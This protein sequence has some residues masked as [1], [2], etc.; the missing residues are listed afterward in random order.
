MENKI[1]SCFSKSKI[2]GACWFTGSSCFIG[3]VKI[4]DEFEGFKYYIGKA[5]GS[6]E[7]DD[8]NNIATWGSP[9]PKEAG[10]KL[11]YEKT[12]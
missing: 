9:F 12:W 3:I 5:H 11:I 2:V 6:N 4:L 8:A 1:L 7:L 10:E